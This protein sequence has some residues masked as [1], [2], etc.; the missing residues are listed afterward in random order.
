MAR[1]SIGEAKRFC[2]DGWRVKPAHDEQDE[3][4]TPKQVKLLRQS[5]R[6]LRQRPSLPGEEMS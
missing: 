4:M 3:N 2:Q 6:S 5:L 1:Q